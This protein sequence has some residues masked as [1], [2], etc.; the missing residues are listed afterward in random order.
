MAKCPHFLPGTW[1]IN[2]LLVAGALYAHLKTLVEKT[3]EKWS[4]SDPVISFSLS[5]FPLLLQTC[6]DLV[7]LSSVVFPFNLGY[8]LLGTFLTVAGICPSLSNTSCLFQASFVYILSKT[9]P[10]QKATNV[11][12]HLFSLE[13]SRKLLLFSLNWFQ[14][15]DLVIFILRNFHPCWMY[16]LWGLLDMG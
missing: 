8:G 5:L 3:T 13:R 7:L 9:S 10:H 6:A 12:T 16:S 1:N 11:A 4:L 14:V 15:L 2:S